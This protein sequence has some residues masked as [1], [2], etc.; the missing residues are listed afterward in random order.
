VNTLLYTDDVNVQD[1][2]GDTPLHNACQMGNVDIVGSLISVFANTNI[3]DDDKTTPVEQAKFFG[4]NEL[5][6]CFSQLL[7]MAC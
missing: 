5:V 7:P 2:D 3:T 1:N 4:N 6:S